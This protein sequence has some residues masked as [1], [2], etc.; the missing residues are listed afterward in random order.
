MTGTAGELGL[1]P[2]ICN[3][4]FFFIEN[5]NNGE[6]FS[7]EASYLEIYNERICDL[8]DSTRSDLKLREHPNT[9]VFV[10]N[11]SSFQVNSYTEIERLLDYGQ[12]SR[13]TASTN[14]NDVS[15][16]SHAV[17]MLNI[18]RES[19]SGRDMLRYSCQYIYIYIPFRCH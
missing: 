11:L 3:A 12:R 9:G 16:R 14:M 6:E 13:T 8:L 18:R 19:N 10:E 17:F 7:V 15:S 2:R 4:L 5:H 1:I